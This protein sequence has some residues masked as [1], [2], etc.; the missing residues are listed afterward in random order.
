MPRK[1]L[2]PLVHATRASLSRPRPCGAKPV[3]VKKGHAKQARRSKKPKPQGVY[4][5]FTGAI[6]EPELR[7]P[8]ARVPAG[9]RRLGVLSWNVGGLRAFLASEDRSAD[10]QKAV[11]EARPEVI[12]LLEHKLQE[13]DRHGVLDVLL[14]VLPDFE[15]GAVNYSTARKG[16]SGSLVLLRKGSEALKVLAEDLPSAANEGRLI[17]VEYKELFVVLCYVPNSGGGLKRLSQRVH[18]WDAELRTRLG[19]LLA[20]KKAVVLMGDLNVAHEDKDIWNAQAP[21]VFKS[22]GT[23]PQERESFTKLLES[24]FVDGFSVSHPQVLGAFT[25]W[26]VRAG[27]RKKNR[28]LRLDYV[29]ASKGMVSKRGDSNGPFLVDTFHLPKLAPGDHCPVGAVIAI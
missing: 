19:V 1:R 7:K 4:T 27:N 12:G 8:V 26:S 17:V 22:A 23:T 14:D 11:K 21:H 18:H 24:G 20:K 29:L 6:P 16:F 25:Y 2:L 3:P 5:G 10:L 13:G 28:G 15:L 9:R